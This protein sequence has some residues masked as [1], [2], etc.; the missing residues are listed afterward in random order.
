MRDVG[1]MPGPQ[2]IYTYTL[3]NLQLEDIQLT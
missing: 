3:R 1:L 2:H